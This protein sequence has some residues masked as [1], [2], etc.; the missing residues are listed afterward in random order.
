M[1]KLQND[2]ISVDLDLRAQKAQETIHRLTKNMEQLKKQNQEHR[3][4]IS[5]LA[6]AEGDFSADIRRLNEDIRKN[7]KEIDANKRAINDE[8]QKIDISRMSA[9][10]LGKELKRLK[11]ELSHTSKATNP[12]RYKELEIQIRNTEKA[13]A[14][15][16]KSS[17]GFLTSMLSLDK[18]STSIKGFFMGL[19]MVIT[20]YVVGSFKNLVATIQDFERSN[21][22]LAAVLQTTISGV[23]RLTEQAKFLGRTTTATASQVTGLQTE[24]AK[25]GFSQD[26]IEKLTPATLKFAKAVD[27]DLSSAAAFAGSAMRMFNKDAGDAE[28][29]MATFAVATSKSALDF[30][31]LQAS[32]STIGPVA[33][34]FGFSV[35]D[36]TALLGQLSNAGFDAS[37][38]ATATRN[39]LLN[40]ADA[41]GA[42]AQALGGPVKNLDGMVAGLQKLNA[43]GVDLNK[44]LEL[45]DK[46]SVAAFT[47]F[48][49]GADNILTLRDSI[50][51]CTG[52]FRN[53][54]KTMADNAAGGW[55]GF[56]SAV[57][58]LVLKFFDFREA[59][60]TVYE[61]ATAIVNWIGEL[62]DAFSPLGSILTTVAGAIGKLIASVGQLV[63]WLTRLFSQTA[64]GRAMLNGLVAA[65]VTFKVA[66]LLA[67]KATKDLFVN[68]MANVKAGL[69]YIKNLGKQVAALFATS[70]ANTTAAATTRSL[71]AAMK[72]NVIMLV[73]SALAALV[74]AIIAYNS[75]TDDATE[76]TGALTEA[77]R[78]AAREY[79]EQKGKIE[80]LIL[81]ANN[82]NISLERRKK[83]VDELNRT[84][85]NYNA[86]I[87][88]TTGKYKASTEALK[89]YLNALEKELRYKANQKKL[90][91]LV[92]E[93]EDKR[94]AFDETEL[95]VNRNIKKKRE[96]QRAIIPGQSSYKPDSYAGLISIPTANYGENEKLE[97]EIWEEANKRA[98]ARQEWKNAQEEVNKM[99]SFID[100]GLDSGYMVAPGTGDNIEKEVTTPI[101]NA[102]AAAHSTVDEVKKLRAELKQLNKEDPKTDEE[103]DSIRDRKK[104]IRE[105]LKELNGSG[106][107]KSKHTPGTYSE[108]SLDEATASAD[109]LH[110]QKLLDINKLKGT[111]PEYDL[112]IKKNQ[113]MIRYCGDLQKAMTALRD[114]TDATH[115]QTLDKIKERENEI[116]VD[117]QASQQAINKATADKEAEAHRQRLEAN[118]AFYETQE[119]EMRRSVNEGKVTEE[120]ADMYLLA[121]K[122]EFHEQQLQELN[123]FY[124]KSKD[125]DYLAADERAKL[126]E[127]TQGDI[128]SMTSQVLT[129]TG[130]LMEKIREL[131]TDTTSADGIRSMYDAQRMSIEQ[132][133]AQAVKTAGL[134]DEQIVALEQNKQRRIAELDYQQQEQQ[135][136]LQ[137]LTGLTWGQEYEREL[138]QLE[139]YHKQGL[140]KEKDY[141]SKKLQ[142]GV[143]NAK[144][145]FDYYSGL[146]GS[147][148]QAIQ[149]AEIAQSDAKFDVLIQQARNNGEDTAA[150][151]EEKENKKLE[152][153]KKYADVNFA[154]KI[155]QIIADT[156]VAIMQAFSQLGPIGGAVAAALITATGIAQVIQAKAER[157]K[158]K[159]MQPGR[160]SGSGSVKA[161]TSP[162]KA[163]RA[164]TGYSEGGYTGDGDRYEV[165]GV[166]HRG[167]YVVPKPIMENPRVIDAVGTIEAIR[168][169]KMAGSGIP[170]TT[171][172]GS[173]ADGGFTT[174]AAMPEFTELVTATQELRE[175]ARNIRAYVVLRD[176]DNARESL[177]RA[178]APF[179]RKP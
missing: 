130:T 39:I 94:M 57:E 141:Q 86:Q 98:R 117:I 28:S 144:K 26:V 179:T 153:Q 113:E 25:L 59:L 172:S 74:T 104:Q 47:T 103:Y 89:E 56:T 128:R 64:L 48:L 151:E 77:R 148:F 1:S 156:A 145:Y 167:E 161:P 20:T 136:Q 44:A 127:K 65:L 126:L 92:S 108:D 96:Q 146:S 83:A 62:V 30:N 135:W 52:D 15:A 87:D 178:R 137:E 149:D 6:A 85:P 58:G 50:T 155:S 67:S 53:M 21:S 166:V 60:K 176:I 9:A 24:L 158:I 2:K 69:Q 32:L 18:M 160:T 173:Y 36:T 100:K 70:A 163:E 138:A 95:K 152:I 13:Y 22:K 116:A 112:V 68:M 175:A 38:A 119:Q 174:P 101:K 99:K 11:S 143:T 31:K 16:T 73:V 124:N 157:D 12:K 129:D 10:D 37:S 55:A 41:N 84:I 40:L 42:L 45:T 88:A 123:D 4:E 118:K 169:N 51:D 5:R 110:Q 3:K 139:N 63:G 14:Q 115:T 125:A 165:A 134:S 177:D 111:I 150:L 132:T 90:E 34:A 133:Y 168:R 120:A 19:G 17:R 91:E 76:K 154:I 121:R 162:A 72:A 78:E 80:A 122:K 105:R 93:A 171:P 114:K 7:T 66:T 142:L 8:R 164:L 109:D 49:N 29:V 170:A 35:E 131:S 102:G 54:T 33:N 97:R 43:E 147:M 61:W 159:N 75:K 79:G 107:S 71:N 27:T 82:E 81:V 23:S 140:I 106:K 46:R